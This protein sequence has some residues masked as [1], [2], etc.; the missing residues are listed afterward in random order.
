[1]LSMGGQHFRANTVFIM[2]KAYL[3]DTIRYLSLSSIL[4]GFTQPLEPGAAGVFQAIPDISHT[5]APE[6]TK[7]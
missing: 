5:V 7:L 1:M 2:V 6:S 4:I 3:D